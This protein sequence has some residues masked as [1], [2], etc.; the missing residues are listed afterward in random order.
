MVIKLRR[1]CIY[2]TKKTPF[3]SFCR[4]IQKEKNG[5]FAESYHFTYLLIVSKK[6]D[7]PIVTSPS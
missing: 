1:I 7:F 6:G 2:I 5:V 4:N 3:F